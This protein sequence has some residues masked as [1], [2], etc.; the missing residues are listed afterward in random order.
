MYFLPD[1][2]YSGMN[3]LDLDFTLNFYHRNNFPSIGKK[4]KNYFLLYKHL[5]LGITNISF[6]I[7]FPSFETTVQKSLQK[8]S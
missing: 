7:S 3:E 5:H 1:K 8:H 6:Y 2:Q 4:K